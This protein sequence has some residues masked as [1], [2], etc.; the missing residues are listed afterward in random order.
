ML[1]AEGP[2]LR[3]VSKD[4][5]SKILHNFHPIPHS[6]V[7]LTVRELRTIEKLSKFNILGGRIILPV[8]VTLVLALD[9]D[10]RLP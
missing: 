6:S 7:A 10:A 2:R 4:H 8:L 1:P 3:G 9:K 5:V